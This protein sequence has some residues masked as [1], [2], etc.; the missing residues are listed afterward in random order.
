MAGVRL[1]PLGCGIRAG[2]AAPYALV[3]SV[4][5]LGEDRKRTLPSALPHKKQV[6]SFNMGEYISMFDNRVRGPRVRT[7]YDV[8]VI[9]GGISGVQIARHSAGRGL[10][11]L[12][13]ERDDFGAGTSSATSKIIHNGLNNMAHQE[14]RVAAE[15]LK[16]GRYLGFAAP[17]L[18]RPHSRLIVGRHWS[19]ARTAFFGAGMAAHGLLGRGRTEGLPADNQA[20]AP[21]W[22][23]KKE[24][25][26]ELSWLEPT[27]LVGA[28]RHDDNLNIHPERLLLALVT[29]VA[30][31]GG[32][33][34]NHAEVTTLL[35]GPGEGITGVRVRDRLSGETADIKAT[36]TINAAGPWVDEVLGA[37]SV[38]A[39]MEIT[40]HKGVHLLC[41]DIGLKEGVA[42]RGENGLRILLTPWQNRTLIGPNEV[43]VDGNADDATHATIADV[44]EILEA[45]DSVS[46]RPFDRRLIKTTIAGVHPRAK[47]SKTERFEI[48][49]H[50]SEGFR[51]L[52]TL[53]G[54][55]WTL[56]RLVGEQ[57][58]ER[59]LADEADRLP[60]VRTFDSR[61]VNLATSFGDYESVAE[62]F[63]AALVRRPEAEL[64]RE[65]RIH[66]AALYG[67]D[68]L[69]VLELISENPELAE[70]LVPDS[71][72]LDIAA[73]AIFA[74]TDEAACGL[75]DVLDRRLAVGTLGT[76][77]PRTVGR[78]ADLI[79][80]LLGWDE[81]RRATEVAEYLAKQSQDTAVLE[82]L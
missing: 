2:Y 32:T 45:L 79:A 34:I 81:V 73:Q 70:R 59:V 58:I 19:K 29:T 10:R 46:R 4:R 30:E 56:G 25:L 68:H 55:S 39:R 13:I 44:N 6:T 14:F 51:G 77:S 5:I 37:W 76:V 23:S 49:N 18:V 15:S 71:D 26:R 9:G 17:H 80:P 40:Q 28:W 75:E 47:G 82:E 20:G 12:L 57:V 22:V 36:V 24:L 53:T 74:V 52:F 72:C 65:E 31:S 63:E 48:H 1:A 43:E 38:P 27:N 54:G 41:G 50:A 69:R 3:A 42:V 64:G 16:E 66:L 21:R 62:S 78:V 60:P 61:Y 8:I 35:G 67:T 11:T 7:N 33:A